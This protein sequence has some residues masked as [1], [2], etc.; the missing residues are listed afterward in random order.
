MDSE[1]TIDDEEPLVALEAMPS[2]HRFVQSGLKEA[3]KD[4]GGRVRRSEDGH[5]G[6]E[7][8]RGIPGAKAGEKRQ[9]E[10]VSLS[11]FS[12]KGENDEHADDPRIRRGLGDTDEEAES[13]HRL[14]GCTDR[15]ESC[16]D[17]P[18]DLFANVETEQISSWAD[19]SD[20]EAWG[21]R[22]YL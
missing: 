1:R 14:D 8:A 5:S 12:N 18:E 9:G 19:A 15:H 2:I 4:V 21:Q 13:V 22:T 6:G 17:A 10:D 16:E 7:L 3:D 20:E 11:R